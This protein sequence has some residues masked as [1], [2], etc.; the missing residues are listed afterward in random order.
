QNIRARALGGSANASLTIH[1]VGGASRSRM[2]AQ[3]RDISL[4][5]L[6]A[7]APRYSLPQANLAGTVS[8][9][10]KVSWGRQ[11]ADLVCQF[12]ATL[13]GRLGANPSAPLNRAGYGD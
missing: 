2:Q 13:E 7:T 11:L 6:E 10:A 3:L 4:E 12:E 1:D 8:A 5:Q 9:D